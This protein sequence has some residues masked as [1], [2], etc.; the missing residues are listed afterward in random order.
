MLSARLVLPDGG[1]VTVSQD[2]NPD[3]FWAIRGAGHNFG[4]VTEWQLRVYDIKN[5]KWGYDIFVFSGDKLE[6]LYTLTND[7]MKTQPP[8][9]THWAYILSPAE[10]NPEHVRCSLKAVPLARF[11]D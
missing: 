6:A 2:S 1:A 4:I 9:V 3:L 8:E 11:G 7:M 10:L 5:P